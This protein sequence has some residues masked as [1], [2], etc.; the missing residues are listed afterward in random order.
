MMDCRYIAAIAGSAGSLK[1]LKEFF[2][3]TPH[4]NVA[5][6]IVQHLPMGF[7]SQLQA[8]LKRHSS[9]ETAVIEE[10]MPVTKDKIFILPASQYAGISSGSFYLTARPPSPNRSI[11]MFLTSLAAQETH[12]PIAIILSGANDD[13]ALGMT[14]IKRTGGFTMAQDP[15]TCEYP[16]MPEKA[17]ARGSIDLVLPC[18]EMPKAIARYVL[19]NT[20]VSREGPNLKN[21][22]N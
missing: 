11:D 20:G 17:I 10:G 5:Y 2:D 18:R 7:R 19:R 6:V 1:P 8:I 13:G 21:E 3:H 22:V 12:K 4:D 16:V 9:L 15:Q 14:S